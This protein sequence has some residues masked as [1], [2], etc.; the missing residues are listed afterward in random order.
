MLPWNDIKS[1]YEI[2]GKKI[3]IF[4]IIKWSWRLIK[5]VDMIY[6]MIEQENSE[7]WEKNHELVSFTLNCSTLNTIVGLIWNFSW[8][9]LSCSIFKGSLDWLLSIWDDNIFGNY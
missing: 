3:N 9:L 1:I 6:V 5:I 7:F 8:S 2:N 4:E